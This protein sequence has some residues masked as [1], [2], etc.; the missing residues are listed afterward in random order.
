MIV[1]LS[2]VAPVRDN[3]LSPFP[4]ELRH[5][6]VALPTIPD[7]GDVAGVVVGVVELLQFVGVGL[8]GD[9]RLLEAV[10][11]GLVVVADVSLQGAGGGGAQG[12]LGGL[13]EVGVAGAEQ[14]TAA[15]LD[16]G[17]QTDRVVAGA[18]DLGAEARGGRFGGVLL[19]AVEVVGR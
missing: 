5:S 9:G 16:G 7:G 10:G 8:V 4:G 2:T 11:A 17:G 14:I 6:P 3:V 18:D 12:Q 13:A 15:A 1:M 19:G